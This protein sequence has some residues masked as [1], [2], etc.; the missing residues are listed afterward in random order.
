[1]APSPIAPTFHLAKFAFS[2]MDKREIA[3]QALMLAITAPTEEKAE[4]CTRIAVQQCFG[5]THSEVN[6]IKLETLQRL[7]EVAQ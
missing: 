1:M 3:I 4:E 5:M 2:D 7:S 6:S